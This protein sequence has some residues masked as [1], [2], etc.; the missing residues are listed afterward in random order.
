MAPRDLPEALT[1]RNQLDALSVKFVADYRLGDALACTDAYTKDGLLLLP[2]LAPI[3]GR[4]EIA[5]ALTASI[6]GGLEVSG[7][8]TM[9]SGADE[10]YG[11]AIQTVHT[12]RGNQIVMLALRCDHGIWR[13]CAEAVMAS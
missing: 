8:T 3:R 12:S 5:A 11:Y 10:K 2:N 13:V 1:F 6:D 4:T 9:E 7:I